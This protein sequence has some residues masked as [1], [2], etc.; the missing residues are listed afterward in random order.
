MSTPNPV[1]ELMTL[2]PPP[3]QPPTN[4][5]DW[6]SVEQSLGTALSTDLKEIVPLLEAG[7]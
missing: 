6:A 2:V 5:G 3:R 7:V 4:Q 1:A